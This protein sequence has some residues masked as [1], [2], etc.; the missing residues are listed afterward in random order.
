MKKVVFVIIMLFMALYVCGQTTI[1]RGVAYRYNGKNPRLPLGGVYLKPASSDNGVV[2]DEKTGSFSLALK[3]CKMGERIGG[4]RVTKQGM[5]V[6]NQDAVDEWSVRKAPLRLILC[7]VNEFEKQKENLIAIGKREAQKKYDKR[8]AELKQQNEARQ[9]ELDDYYNKLD[10]LEKELQNAMK[11]MDEYAEVF[12]RIDESEIDSLAQRAVELFHKGEIEESIRLLEEG[13]YEKR[14]DDALRTKSQAQELRHLADSAEALAD[15][16]IDRCMN[17][18]KTQVS[19]Y[20]LNNE[21]QKAGTLLKS[22]A[23]KLQ[24]LD[25]TW[26]YAKF[27]YDQN[28]FAEAE[29]YFLKFEDILKRTPGDNNDAQYVRLYINL[30]N[31]YCNVL[32]FDK[33]EEM[34]KKA[35][36]ILKPLY[37]ATPETYESD[38]ATAYLNLG[39]TYIDTDRLAEGKE[40]Y[41]K[42]M[43]MLERL[44]K[45]N[46]QKNEPTLQKLYNNLGILYYFTDS[47]DRSEEMYNK[48]RAIVERLV[49][50]DP[51]EYAPIVAKLYSNLGVL[52][53]W[54]NRFAES[55]EI[56][57][58]ALKVRER[59]AKRNPE[60]HEPDLASSYYNLGKTYYRAKHF[61]ESEEMY[62]MALTILER[63][64]KRNPEKYEPELAKLYNNMQ[65]LYSDVKRLDKCEEVCEARYNYYSK[66][67]EKDSL[68]YQEG[69]TY[70]LLLLG[71]TKVLNNKADEAIKVYEQSLNYAKEIAQEGKDSSLYVVGLSHLADLYIKAKDYASAY[72]HNMVLLSMQHAKEVYNTRLVVQSFLANLLGKF[73]EG[74][75]YSLEALQSDSANHVAYTNLAAALLFKGRVAE[76]EKLYRQYKQELKD[77]FL[78]DL[79]EYERLKVIPKERI[80]DVERIRKML[81]AQ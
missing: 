19:A 31:V 27:C 3:N 12:A 56:Q 66:L 18:I 69:I 81:M 74:E 30:G 33:S 10:S 20:K 50:T 34:H 2:S 77:T 65:F 44:T 57:K 80:A 70:S 13:N 45:E 79:A 58:K 49:V 63:L 1:Q 16:D 35:L 9:L 29:T 73:N 14:L 61:A 52:Y 22:M 26:D 25:A 39:I 67:Y 17:A 78:D 68:R 53:F 7:D 48:A 47:L 60:A 28:Q 46:P 4:V 72:N 15:N 11:H 51:V 76:A 71:S 64:A 75:T 8:L 24:T 37:E 6:F 43:A 32:R 21:F 40:I 36:V 59:L 23:D 42:A 41:K 54:T 5:M 55:E 62:N 38:M